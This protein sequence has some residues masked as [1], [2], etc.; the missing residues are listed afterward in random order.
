MKLLIVI[1][2]IVL[3]VRVS[4]WAINYKRKLE[5]GT[6]CVSGHHVIPLFKRNLSSLRESLQGLVSNEQSDPGMLYIIGSGKQV[7]GK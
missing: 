3:S 6:F 7:A 5:I 4:F 2:Y 1:I